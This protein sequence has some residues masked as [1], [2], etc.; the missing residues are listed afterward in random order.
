MVAPSASCR[1]WAVPS[2]CA[3]MST[4]LAILL[5]SACTSVPAPP[6]PTADAPEVASGWT[7]K[8][9]V[10]TRS[11]MVVAANPLAVDA[12]VAVLAEGGSAVDAAI[13]VQMVLNVVEPQSSGIGGGALLMAYTA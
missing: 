12:G 3:R 6:A 11:D 13:A 7:P 1:P 10:H 9:I 4:V 2:W 8:R 5:G